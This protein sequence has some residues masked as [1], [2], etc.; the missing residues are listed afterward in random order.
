[1]DLIGSKLE[2]I[3]RF[4]E[5]ERSNIIC[6]LAEKDNE[7]KKLKKAILDLK[8]KIKEDTVKKQDELLGAEKA[9]KKLLLEI[10]ELKQT[11]SATTKVSTISGDDRE[12]SAL[13]S[14][15][16]KL[17]DIN[18]TLIKEL[19]F[20][21][22]LNLNQNK[23]ENLILVEE[24]SELIGSVVDSPPPYATETDSFDVI[25]QHTKEV[26]LNDNLSVPESL[27]RYATESA[28]ETYN[29]SN[30]N[31]VNDV[32]TEH[33]SSVK[34]DEKLNEEV[35]DS[36][37]KATVSEMLS[38]PPLYSD[39]F[40]TLS[41]KSK[42]SKEVNPSLEM[43]GSSYNEMYS[44]KLQDLEAYIQLE[45]SS[46][47]EKITLIQDELKAAKNLVKD[48]KRQIIDSNRN[49]S[50]EVIE[51][52]E[53]ISKLTMEVKNLNAYIIQIQEKKEREESLEIDSL[54]SI[55]A[56]NLSNNE[57]SANES[58][59]INPETKEN[60][61]VKHMQDIS[62]ERKE[63]ETT[64]TLEAKKVSKLVHYLQRELSLRDK[65]LER[66]HSQQK[67]LEDAVSALSRS[68]QHIS[69][70]IDENNKLK[71]EIL[72]LSSPHTACA[73]HE[74]SS[75]MN[76]DIAVPALSTDKK[77]N[78]HF[79]SNQ[80]QTPVSPSIQ[81]NN[82]RIVLQ[83]LIRSSMA[84]KGNTM[85]IGFNPAVNLPSLQATL[86]TVY[87]PVSSKGSRAKFKN[88]KL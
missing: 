26:V 80:N 74:V 34:D 57:K 22:K 42:K 86:K 71:S 5:S 84:A 67:H 37:S 70:L 23:P 53:T 1:M 33:E 68:N 81:T 59:I 62:A 72:S 77:K 30:K 10:K 52:K 29:D 45:R 2:D 25:S 24:E 60:V 16:K 18:K 3:R 87:R 41:N 51:S 43:T 12:V 19:Q 63:N 48:M 83:E 9:I 79:H 20:V 13:K 46:L 32:T 14:K 15:N 7:N 85:A 27:S 6:K 50:M 56:N 66:F 61:N 65:R 35:A 8:A 55:F 49:K 38:L 21:K 31:I 44:K 64:E 76:T 78:I 39:S 11:S 4:S 17:L 73:T 40:V 82:D 58:V 88:L 54:L 36:E 75:N 69:S 28:L 47:V